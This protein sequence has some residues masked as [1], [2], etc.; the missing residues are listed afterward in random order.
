MRPPRSSARSGSAAWHWPRSKSRGSTAIAAVALAVAALTLAWFIRVEAR[1]GAG[2]LVPLDMF[3]ARE[4]RGAVA[5]TA[6]MTFGMYGV[7][8]LLPLVWQSTGRLGPVGGGLAL[9]PMALAFVLVSPFSGTLAGRLGTRVVTS[10]GVAVI[11]CGLLLIGLCAGSASIVATEIGLALTGVGMGLA[12]G[13]LMGLAVGTVAAA[14]SGTA[15]A[16]I[17]VA[18]MVG[19][20]IG[21]AVLGAVFATLEGGPEGL[22]LAMLLGGLVQLSSAAALWI[23]TRPADRRADKR[24]FALWQ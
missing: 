23:A 13:P 10:G 17:N 9:M 24:L 18:R 19:A 4:F 16:L 21:V 5:A 12:T 20:T 22:Q 6:G 1:R 8:F 2:A 7:L 15:A 11:G 14:R 3:G